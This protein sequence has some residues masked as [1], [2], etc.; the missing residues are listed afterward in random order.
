MWEACKRNNQKFIWAIGGWSDLTETIR[1]DQ[2]D[3]FVSKIIAMLRLG[4]DG[5]DFDWEHLGQDLALKDQQTKTI[6]TVLN[7]LR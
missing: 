2:V 4:G 6:A 5:V 7:R 3:L 1:M